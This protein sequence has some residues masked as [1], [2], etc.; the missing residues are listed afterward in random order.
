MIRSI[1]AVSVAALALTGTA[2]AGPAATHATTVKVT[3]KDYAF[4]LSA[5]KVKPGRVTFV[6]RNTGAAVHDF[7]IA[8][9]HSKTI[10]HG[11]TTRLAVMLKPGKYHYS[12]TVDSHAELGMKG[13]LRVAG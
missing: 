9:H 3:A 10:S 7:A 4:V 11:Q 8:G 5:T 6:I 1:L 2:L 12:C 13:T